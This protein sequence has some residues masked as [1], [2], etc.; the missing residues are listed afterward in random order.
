M[1]IMRTYNIFSIL[2]ALILLG[3]LT[4]YGAS[5]TVSVKSMQAMSGEEVAIPIMIKDAEG[6]GAMQLVLTYDESILEARSVE[7]DELLEAN[8]LMES[9]IDKPGRIAVALTTLDGIEGDGTLLTANF[10]VRGQEGQRSALNLESVEAWEVDTLVDILISTESGEFTVQS[11]PAPQQ[12][13]PQQPSGCLIATAAFGSELTP[14]VQF[15]RQFRD[16]KILNTLAGSSFMNVFNAWYYSF[17]PYVADYEREQPWLQQIVKAG[18]YPLIGILQLS[19]VGY[20]STHGEYGALTAGFIA[21]SMIGALYFWPFALSI[22]R[23]RRGR[24]NY[25]LAVSVIAIAFVSVIASMI[26][27]NEYALMVSTSIFVLSLLATAAILSVKLSIALWR[28]IHIWY[29]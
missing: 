24:F 17:S 18:V 2:S 7:K 22:K 27:G 11:P 20:S 16:Q 10:V 13:Q 5:V 15:L 9:N 26:S 12:A 1:M 3:T 28:F 8:V 4:A 29:R 23:I 25:K 6:I 14:Q 19:E 21:S